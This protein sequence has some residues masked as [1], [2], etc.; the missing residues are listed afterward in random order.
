MHEIT[1]LLNQKASAAELVIKISQID[2]Q[3]MI[4]SID[5]ASFIEWSS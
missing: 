1:N 2:I 3:L 4:W 5:E